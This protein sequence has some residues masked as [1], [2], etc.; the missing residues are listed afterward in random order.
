M[1][2]VLL[3]GVG[4]VHMFWIKT[5]DSLLSLHPRQSS[6]QM[7]MRKNN[8]ARRSV[9][10][11]EVAIWGLVACNGFWNS[12]WVGWWYPWSYFQFSVPRGASF[13]HRL[14]GAVQAG[15]LAL[16]NLAG[17]LRWLSDEIICKEWIALC[18]RHR[19]CHQ[20]LPLPWTV[21]FLRSVLLP[22]SASN[23]FIVKQDYRTSLS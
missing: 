1:A 7:E 8:S 17:A 20:V 2:Q 22:Y 19:L 9:S 3:G 15:L 5:C 11:W 18:P 16:L 14:R 21:C 4:G 23:L 12:E 6:S 13:T 10:R